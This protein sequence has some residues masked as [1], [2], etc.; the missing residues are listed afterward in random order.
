MAAIPE[1]MRAVDRHRRRRPG[2][3]AASSSA[4][5]RGPARARSCVKVA[6]AGVNRP[7]VL[8]RQGHYPPPPGAPDILGLEIAGEVAALGE[9][10]H[11]LP[12]ATAVDGARRRAA[13]MRNTPVVHESNALPRPGTACPWTR[14]APSRR[15]SSRSGPTSSSAAR[16]KAG[17]DAAGAW[18]H[19]RHRHDG[20]PTRQGLRRHASSP[21]PGGARNARPAASSAPTSRSITARPIS[22]QPCRRRPAA[23]A[24]T[25]SSTWSAATTSR[26][27]TTPRR[28]M[29]ASSRSPSSKAAEAEVDFRRLMVKRL[30]HTGSTLRARAVAEKAAIAARARGEGAAAPGRGPL[31]AGDRCDA[32]P[33]PTRRRPMPA[34]K[35]APISARSC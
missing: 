28:G 16:L 20:D 29:A 2:G 9:G 31:P 13:A 17:R 5:C 3:P 33:L 14:P 32:F 4:R 23:A 15:P 27:T 21:P 6:A 18:R 11:A 1:T 8:Q 26:A 7:D 25:S 35:A 24:P 30:T 12:S 19:L 10:A 22:S 34:W